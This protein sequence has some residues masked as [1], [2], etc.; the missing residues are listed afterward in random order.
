ML[1][2][3]I[4]GY[5]YSLDR[6]IDAIAHI[7]DAVNSKDCVMARA[8]LDE[9]N[10]RLFECFKSIYSSLFPRSKRWKE[11]EYKNVKEL[12]KDYARKVV[13]LYFSV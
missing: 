9:S 2:T 10:K 11:E 1:P 8:W 12:Y 7:D 4:S 13:H 3:N 6:F 5:F